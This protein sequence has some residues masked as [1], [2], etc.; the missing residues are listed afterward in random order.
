M[1]Q[2]SALC[3]PYWAPS[4]VPELHTHKLL[5]CLRLSQGHF[6]WLRQWWF[7]GCSIP[8]GFFLLPRS[9]CGSN[10][11]PVPGLD[12]HTCPVPCRDTSQ[13]SASSWGRHCFYPCSVWGADALHLSVGKVSEDFSCVKTSQTLAWKKGRGRGRGNLQTK[14]DT[15]QFPI[16]LSL[17]S[18]VMEMRLSDVW[19]C[20][21]FSGKTVLD[22]H[23]AEL[24]LKPI[25]YHPHM[26]GNM[27]T[28]ERN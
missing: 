8:C 16:S 21:I 5:K 4:W 1:P 2:T 11:L 25:A 15:H 12:A 19:C 3:C 6:M 22:F 9:R 28:A 17:F 13:I 18:A 26:L 24:L 20:P 27:V 10:L 14:V 23:I 7:S